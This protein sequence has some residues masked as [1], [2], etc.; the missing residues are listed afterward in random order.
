MQHSQNFP[1]P[2]SKGFCVRKIAIAATG[3][4]L[5]VGLLSPTQ[6]SAIDHVNTSK[7]RKAVT[8]S[9]I[10]QHERALQRIANNNDGTRASGTPGYAASANYVVKKLRK[11]G[12]KVKRQT[13]TFPFFQELA[14]AELSVVTPQPRDIETVTYTY[15]GSGEVTGQ[16]VPIDVQI[17]PGVEAN[18]STSGCESSDFPAPASGPAIAL[19]QRGTC[20]FEQ[21]VVNA[22]EAGYDA[23]IIFNEGQQG[24]QELFQGTLGTPQ[25]TPTVGAS[26][27]D[28]EALYSA[29]QA[30]TVTV[31]VFTSTVNENRETQNIIADSPKGKIKG[32]TIVVGAHLDSVIAGPGINDN[33]SGSAT[34]LEIA[35]QLAK[36]KYTKKLQRQVR[37]AFWGAEELNLL[38]STYYVDHLTTAQQAKIYANLNFDM[39]GSPNYVRF[40]YD[41]DGS[42]TPNAGPPGSDAI[43]QIFLDYFKSKGLAS[44]PT[45]FDGRSDYGPFI[46]VGIPA[47]GLFSG[48]EG[49]KTPEE[50]AI[51][52]G[53]AGVAY[54]KCYHQACDTINNLNSK[55][56]SELG[57]AAAHATLTLA[58]SKAGLHP[59]GSG[60]AEAK[61]TGKAAKHSFKLAS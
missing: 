38:G 17:P 59:D 35:E 49:I 32:Q 30:G 31:R 52:G 7:L 57:D 13:F 61:V 28:G 23:V 60:H 45:A 44:E 4:L 51:Y 5:S 53:T 3:V 27:A 33:G 42:D 29:T 36:L 56:L 48:A 46:E 19:I 10:L 6:A 55:A 41:G 12:Y 43:E 24:R 20:T 54:D 26:F 18:S 37:F 39:L 16:L 25:S 50:A 58:L 15:S 2:P 11:A 9:G 8:V 14:P 34:I 47:G 1:M 21:K 40:V 22:R